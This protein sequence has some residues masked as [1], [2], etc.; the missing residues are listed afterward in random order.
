MEMTDISGAVPMLKV[1][2]W[3][4]T[5]TFSVADDVTP[6]QF[7]EAVERARQDF[8]GA[9][10]GWE[11]GGSARPTLGYEDGM[12]NVR[13]IGPKLPDREVEPPD[14]EKTLRGEVARHGE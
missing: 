8:P 11:Y 2:D 10:V 5:L 12:V 14:A 3:G 13:V 1:A 4:P 6:E 9:R 7:L